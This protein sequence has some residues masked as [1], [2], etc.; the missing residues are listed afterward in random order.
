MIIDRQAES[1]IRAV[2]TG[3]PARPENIR[4]EEGRV[5]AA[6]R[7]Q[8]LG[9]RAITLWVTGLPASGK[10]SI[11][12]HLERR[13]HDDGRHAVV[14][15]GDNLR[16]GLNRDLSFSQRG[17]QREHPAHRRGGPALQPGRHHR[18]RGRHLAIPGGPRARA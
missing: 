8:R 10:S 17:A 7:E 18:P 14:L 2:L 15:D 13:L 16:F 9:Q 1:R 6:E 11:A 3:A 5:T 12:K 4:R